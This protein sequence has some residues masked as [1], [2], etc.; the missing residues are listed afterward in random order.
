[1]KNEMKNKI[2]RFIEKQGKGIKRIT[3][4]I[5]AMYLIMPQIAYAGKSYIQPLTKLKT[6][7]ITISGAA[8]AVLLVFGGIRFAVAFQ[9][10][11]QNGEHA[12]VY[13][14]IAAGVLIGMSAIVAALS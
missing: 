8:G 9:K 11:D 6:I 1:M 10:M 7:I 4:F 13:T 3:A 2:K 12:A 14:M 5:F